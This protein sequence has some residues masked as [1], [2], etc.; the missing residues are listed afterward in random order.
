M[1]DGY[2]SSI[3]ALIYSTVTEK[4]RFTDGETK[5]DNGCLRHDIS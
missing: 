3:L 5:T 4:Y 2:I 1:V